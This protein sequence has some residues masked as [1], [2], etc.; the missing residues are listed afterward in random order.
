[1]PQDDAS[2]EVCQYVVIYS[3]FAEGG[4][5]GRQAYD[6]GVDIRVDEQAVRALGVR[7]L[8]LFGSHA[9]GTA[10]PDSDIDVGVLM[11]GAP[12]DVTDPRCGEIIDALNVKGEVD[13]VFLDAAEPLLLM[14]VAAGRLLFEQAPGTFEE[15]RLRA[16]K[17][18]YD[19][20]WI[21]EIEAD[22]LRRRYA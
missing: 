21:R 13:L 14:E 22:A 17:R 8:V 11:G 5:P 9:R 19:T 16:A 10:R 2:I 12:P 4:L 3:V 7:L 20:A 18:Y 1:M 15:F 6:S